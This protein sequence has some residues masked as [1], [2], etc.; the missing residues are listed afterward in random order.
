MGQV[1]QGGGAGQSR[2]GHSRAGQGL[3]FLNLY[4]FD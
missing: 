2:A 1:V 4:Y 3:I